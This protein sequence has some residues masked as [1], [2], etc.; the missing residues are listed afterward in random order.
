MTF[1]QYGVLNDAERYE[2]PKTVRLLTLGGLAE[3]GKPSFLDTSAIVPIESVV[4]GDEQVLAARGPRPI[5]EPVINLDALANH[6]SVRSVVAATRIKASRTL[7]HISELLLFGETPI[8]D[9]DTI[10][11]L[12]GL[13]HVWFTWAR[14]AEPLNIEALPTGLEALGL[15]RH[16]IRPST[17]SADRF[18][19][20]ERFRDL[21]CL[22]ITYCLP[23]DSVEA[24]GRLVNLVEFHCDAPAGWSRL[25]TCTALEH[26]TASPR[27]SNLRSLRTWTRLRR[28]TLV[29]GAGLPSLAGLEGFTGLERLRL[30]TMRDQDIS[31]VGR[32]PHLAEIELITFGDTLDLAALSTLPALTS[33]RIQSA[34]SDSSEAVRIDTLQPLA[35]VKTLEVLMLYGV[36]GDLTRSIEE[37]HRSRPDID[38]RWQGGPMA[39]SGERVGLVL[40]RPPTGQSSTWWIREDLASRLG[41]PTNYDAERILQR[42]IHRTDRELTAR[43][44]FDS[45]ADAVCIYASELDIRNVAEMISRL[46]FKH[47]ALRGDARKSRSNPKT[48]R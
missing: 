7:P 44:R 28:L 12:P 39:P 32:L 19:V 11:C 22:T 16:H 6:T 29:A 24:I 9:A 38:V 17:G 37:L 42:T 26:V 4:A 30:V 25:R 20:F 14:S 34:H 1:R 23:K 31:P 3:P 35:G 21:R 45:E 18:S 13:T 5:P 10:R 2:R 36:S 48:P 43:L 27:M 47:P 15:G 40:V 46:A 41:V 33:L 8:P